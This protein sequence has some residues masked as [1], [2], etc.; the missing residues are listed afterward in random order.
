MDDKSSD[1]ELVGEG[2]VLKPEALALFL[3]EHLPNMTSTVC[4]TRE[5]DQVALALRNA[6]PP[7]LR[8]QPVPGTL[9][10][11][12][13]HLAWEAHRKGQLQSPA[14]L[15]AYYIRRSDAELNWRG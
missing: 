14:E 6:L 1:F 15:D 5:H 8:W 10:A 2:R 7:T 11:G 12:I 13:A 9:V 3:A 4:L